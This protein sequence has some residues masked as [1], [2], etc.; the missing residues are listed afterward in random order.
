MLFYAMHISKADILAR[1]EAIGARGENLIDIGEAALLLANLDLPTNCLSVYHDELN[2]ITSDMSAASQG[3][4]TL[5]DRIGVLSDTLYKKHRYQGD[6][7]TYDDPQN[8][9][10]MRVIDRRKGLPV[11]L[12]ILAIHAG[13]SQGWEI[14]GLNFPGHFLLQLSKSGEQALIDPFDEA[15]LVGNEDLQRIFRRIHDRQMP[16]RTDFI[17]AISDRDIL[18]RLQNNI[19]IRALGA[20]NRKRAIEILQSIILIVPGN[21]ELLAEL[22]LLEA[23]AG[24]IKSALAH[25][26]K[27]MARNPGF[28]HANKLLSLKERLTRSLN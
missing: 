28:A 9:N 10:L 14:S 18:V 20:G 16:R 19:K 12:G 25:I 17:Q 26:E 4:E 8:A 2:L 3:A 15:R 13:R 27:F 5:R 24:N 7:E 23:S 1:F 21:G 22:A 6:L 11:A